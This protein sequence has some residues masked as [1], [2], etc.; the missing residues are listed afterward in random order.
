MEASSTLSIIAVFVVI[1]ALEFAVA[2]VF[3]I[4]ALL[5][6]RQAARAVEVLTYRVDEEVDHVGTLMRSGWMKVVQT[7]VSGMFGVWEGRRRK[8]RKD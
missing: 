8:D 4:A 3:L 5:H 7:A 2:L 1:I 6:I